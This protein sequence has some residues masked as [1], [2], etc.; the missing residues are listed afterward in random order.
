MA[1]QNQQLTIFISYSRADSE[2]VDRLDADLRARGYRTWVDRRRLEGGVDWEREINAAVAACDLFLISLSP[3]AVASPYV[4]QEFEEGQR[5][6]KRLM[7]VLYQHHTVPPWLAAAQRIQQQDFTNSAAYQHNLKTLLY[8]IQD[9]TLDLSAGNDQLYNRALSMR[10]SDPE[11]AAI[12][13]QHITDRAPTYF[14]G[15]AQRDLADLEAQLY[16]ARV[17][18]LHAQ[19]EQARREG[20]YGVEAASLEALLAL[21]DRDKS[22][23]AWAREYLPIAQQNREMLGPYNVIL[24]RIADGDVSTARTLL[25]NLWEQAP[26]FRDPANIAPALGLNLPPTYIHDQGVAAERKRFEQACALLSGELSKSSLENVRADLRRQN[27]DLDER[28]AVT[29]VE[30]IVQTRHRNAELVAELEMERKT[31]PWWSSYSVEENLFPVLFWIIVVVLV[32]F[33]I[34]W[35]VGWNI[36]FGLPIPNTGVFFLLVDIPTA[37]ALSVLAYL[38]SDAYRGSRE[39]RLR[40]AADA[41]GAQAEAAYQQ[42]RQLA[43]RVLQQRIDAINRG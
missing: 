5:L 27:Y 39:K 18:R 35:I 19:A 20:Q 38:R 34:F 42:W 25:Q 28:L 7:P 17:A 43:R 3:P 32:R 36:S 23:I 15:Q 41:A 29:S 12:I 10:A 1:D 24:Q 37:V 33:L 30:Q 4:R 13:L 2:F 21:G 40:H 26:Y 6:G 8:A 9:P 16:S 14:G 31:P 11:R 22:A